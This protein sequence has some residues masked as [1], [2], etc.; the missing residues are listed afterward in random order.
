MKP[1]S[2]GVPLDDPSLQLRTLECLEGA[3]NYNRWLADLALPY[4]GAD[5]LEIGSGLG[6]FASSWLQLG[7]PHMTV[8]ELE[9][10]GAE[11]LRTR[12]RGD[13]RVEVLQLDVTQPPE[14]L[15][16]FSAAVALNVFE[17]I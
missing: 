5:P 8:S 11:E 10:E 16:R 17:H 6:Y 14:G 2:Q 3:R 15:R 12:F 13:S 1:T 9:P 7:A 4:L